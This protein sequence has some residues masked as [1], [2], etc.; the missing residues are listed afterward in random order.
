MSLPI[1]SY[2]LLIDATQLGVASKRRFESKTT[3]VSDLLGELCFELDIPVI[4]QPDKI[5]EVWDGEF[6]EW[7]LL[8]DIFKQISNKAKVRILFKEA[9]G[10]KVPPFEP[11]PQ[12]FPSSKLTSSPPNVVP[13]SNVN[14]NTAAAAAPF[15]S[16]QQQQQQQHS[17]SSVFKHGRIEVDQY[18]VNAG[19]DLK[20]EDDVDQGGYSTKNLYG[21]LSKEEYKQAISK[22]NQEVAVARST[23]LDL[24]LLAAGPM[25][26]PLIPFGIRNYQHKKKYKQHLMTAIDE[27]NF[28]H[29]KLEMKWLRK[30]VSKL[31]IDWKVIPPP[32]PTEKDQVDQEGGAAEKVGQQ[33]HASSEQVLKSSSPSSSAASSRVAEDSNL[34]NFYSDQGA[35]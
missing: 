16:A 12:K 34:I 6:E 9:P 10:S 24:A 27:F 14:S 29:P 22:I 5:I 1:A 28:Y 18:C 32:P 3:D 13:F 31:V 4:N 20:F 15:T 8:T 21:M 7:V 30:P 26:L 19:L 25:M 2:E 11:Q 17:S 33:Q 23:K 35:V